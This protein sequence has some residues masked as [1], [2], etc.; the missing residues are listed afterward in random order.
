MKAITQG[1]KAIV[2][3]GKP[4]TIRSLK[5]CVET[6]EGWKMCDLTMQPNIRPTERKSSGIS[7]RGE[8][9]GRDSLKQ[10]PLRCHWERCLLS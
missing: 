6:V 5:S 2:S 10:N 4:R 8:S 3:E 9:L 7:Q 1:T